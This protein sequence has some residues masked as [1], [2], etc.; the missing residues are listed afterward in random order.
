MF[1][2]QFVIQKIPRFLR[3]WILLAFY[4]WML[5][6]PGNKGDMKKCFRIKKKKVDRLRKK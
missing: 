2:E 1:E 5:K 6:T 4:I 3:L